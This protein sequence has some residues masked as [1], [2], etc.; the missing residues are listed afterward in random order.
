MTFFAIFE[1]GSAL[2]GAATSSPMLITGRSI[3]GTGA[4]GLMSGVLSIIAVVVPLRLRPIYTG[5]LAAMLGISTIAGPLIGGAFTE[6]V[7]WRWVFYINLPVGGVTV[8]ALVFMFDPPNR[9]VEQDPIME[10]IKRL[11]LPGQLCLCPP[12]S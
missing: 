11:D 9:R 12:S 7:T 4:A 2:S 6:H 3:A 10:R 5:I 8:A 1:L